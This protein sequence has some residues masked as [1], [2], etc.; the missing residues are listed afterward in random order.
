MQSSWITAQC[1]ALILRGK[2]LSGTHALVMPGRHSCACGEQRGCLVWLA[3]I[4]VGV[5]RMLDRRNWAEGIHEGD[6]V[7]KMPRRQGFQ[8]TL[9]SG[10]ELDQ[11]ISGLCLIC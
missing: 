8:R 3:D 9:S 5:Q 7:Q 1:D 10:P 11:S 6:T 4:G 2:V